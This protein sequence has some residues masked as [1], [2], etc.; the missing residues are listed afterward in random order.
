[1]IKQREERI[2]EDYDKVL[3][4]KMQGLCVCVHVHTHVVHLFVCA[5]VCVCL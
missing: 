2:R 1:M 3:N 5:C 4:D